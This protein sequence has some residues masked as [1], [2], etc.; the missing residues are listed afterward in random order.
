MRV[1]RDVA[2]MDVGNG[3]NRFIEVDLVLVIWDPVGP[4]IG[5]TVLS[6]G[7]GIG[8]VGHWLLPLIYNLL[9]YLDVPQFLSEEVVVSLKLLD[10]LPIETSTSS[11]TESSFLCL[12][13][14]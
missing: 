2:L 5:P 8:Q 3:A 7:T 10:D 9:L 12:S 1:V 4:T 6:T 11:L 13:I 14:S